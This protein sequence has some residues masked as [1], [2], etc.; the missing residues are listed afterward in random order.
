VF[1]AVPFAN[2][3]LGEFSSR[4][5]SAVGLTWDFH[6]KCRVAFEVTPYLLNGH[7]NTQKHGLKELFHIV[8]GLLQQVVQRQQQSTPEKDDWLLFTTCLN[9]IDAVMNWE[10]ASTGDAGLFRL[11]AGADVEWS[12]Q[13]TQKFPEEWRDFLLAPEFTDLFFSVTFITKCLL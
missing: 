3:L 6:Y 8:L 12:P 2:A 7:L 5:A 13:P 4:K 10:F 1:L 9:A 11:L